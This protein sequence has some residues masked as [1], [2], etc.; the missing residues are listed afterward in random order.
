V[1]SDEVDRPYG[2]FV[3]HPTR[4]QRDEGPVAN[5]P[6]LVDKHTG[7]VT[8]LVL[9]DALARAERMALAQP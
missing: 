9:P 4:G 7:T 3:Q 5:G 2:A 1:V 8:R 6:H